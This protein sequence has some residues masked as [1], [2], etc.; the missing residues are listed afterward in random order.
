MKILNNKYAHNIVIL[1]LTGIRY[2]AL[3]C[4]VS[5]CHQI[6][7]GCKP[8]TAKLACLIECLNIKPTR[9]R[10]AKVKVLLAQHNPL[11]PPSLSCELYLQGWSHPNPC[12]AT[13]EMSAHL[14]NEKM[15]HHQNPHD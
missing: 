9:G 15:T 5:S 14:E 6:T 13:L 8:R 11:I 10:H 2:P 7:P 4:V 1:A 3:R 12:T